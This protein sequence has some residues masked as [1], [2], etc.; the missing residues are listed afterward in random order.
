[1]AGNEVEDLSSLEAKVVN[2]GVVVEL[3]RRRYDQNKIYVSNILAA[4][5]RFLPNSCL[6][7]PDFSNLA[8]YMQCHLLN[9]DCCLTCFN[10]Y[11]CRQPSAIFCSP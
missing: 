6:L 1:M 7:L 5:A 11:N 8:N 3:L 2:E 9:F 10:L 4:R